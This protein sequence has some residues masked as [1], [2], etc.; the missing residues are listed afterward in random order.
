MP[1]GT[2]SVSHSQQLHFVTFSRYH[3]QPK[4]ATGQARSVF[5]QP[6]EQTRRAYSLRVLGHVAMP[7]HV[8]LLLTEPQTKTLSSALQALKQSA[9]R[10][11]ALRAAEPFWQARYYDFN[12]WGEDKWVEKLR[13]MHRIP[14]P[15][16]ARALCVGVRIRWCAG[17]GGSRVAV[18]R[19][20]CSKV[21]AIPRSLDLTENQRGHT[22]PGTALVAR[23]EEWAWSSF[24]HYATGFAGAVEIESEGTARKREQLGVRPAVRTGPVA[25]FLPWQS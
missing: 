22:Y 19:T 9:F 11:L 8:H 2:T 12:V 6:L 21:D 18:P 24:R 13:Y 20:R 5:E 1:R 16:D 14:G 25:R 3:R 17:Y 15:P 4:L 10:T 7:E 23:P